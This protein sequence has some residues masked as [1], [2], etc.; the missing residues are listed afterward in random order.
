[1]FLVKLYVSCTLAHIIELSFSRHMIVSCL[2]DA[3]G[4]TSFFGD[5]FCTASS[6]F[7]EAMF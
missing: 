4:A 7:T 5:V 3:S 6:D 1:M 2:G